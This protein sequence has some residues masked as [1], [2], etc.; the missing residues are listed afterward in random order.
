MNDTNSN[1]R[2]VRAVGGHW[3]D[4]IKLSAGLSEI[5]PLKIECIGK[6]ARGGA[7]NLYEITG[8]RYT[9]FDNKTVHTLSIPFHTGDPKEGFTGVT[10]EALLTVVID[11]LKG[12]QTGLY[13]C[14]EN[15][16]AL[17]YIQAGLQ[18][19]HNRTKRIEETLK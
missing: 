8:F 11:R 9:G 6:A 5:K 10:M 14:V 18:Q 2:P 16:H 17:E 12:L 3:H 1:A 15:D 19:L 4:Y 7:N 13:P